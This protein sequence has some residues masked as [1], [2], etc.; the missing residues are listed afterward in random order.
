[1]SSMSENICEK[2]EILHKA[3]ARAAGYLSMSIEKRKVQRSKLDYHSS[4]L[5]LVCM[6]VD[7]IIKNE[8]TVTK[9]ISVEEVKVSGKYSYFKLT[10]TLDDKKVE[11]FYLFSDESERALLK[12]LIDMLVGEHASVEQVS[13]QTDAGVHQHNETRDVG[14]PVSRN[15][16]RKGYSRSQT[17]GVATEESKGGSGISRKD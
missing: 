13:R 17:H 6:A 5:R 16:T 15:E 11:R 12:N 14:K 9:L 3:V 2:L 8:H 10:W 7:L 4:N 1:M